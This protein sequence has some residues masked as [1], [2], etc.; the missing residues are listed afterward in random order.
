MEFWFLGSCI[1]LLHE[2]VAST[3][4]GFKVGVI[5]AQKNPVPS[6]AQIIQKVIF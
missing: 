6:T 3:V 1:F 4:G 2:L 5:A